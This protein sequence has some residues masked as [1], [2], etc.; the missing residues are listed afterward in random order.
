MNRYRENG[1]RECALLSDIRTRRKTG[2]LC[3]I[4]LNRRIWGATLESGREIVGSRAQAIVG[5]WRAFREHFDCVR[6][7][8]VPADSDA[9]AL[10]QAE[11]M[12]SDYEVTLQLYRI[13][14]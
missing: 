1:L 5:A 11:V 3:D 4:A 12:H 8:H 14:Q 7:W 9:E 13:L 10:S 6:E 2:D